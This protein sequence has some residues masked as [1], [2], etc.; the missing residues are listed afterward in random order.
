VSETKTPVAEAEDPYGWL[1]VLVI[2]ATAGILI[3][4]LVWPLILWGFV[5]GGAYSLAGMRPGYAGKLLYLLWTGI[6]VTVGSAIMAQGGDWGAALAAYARLQWELVLIGLSYFSSAT[7]APAGEI[8]WLHLTQ[9]PVIGCGIAFGPVLGILFGRGRYPEPEPS[10]GDA[11]RGSLPPE[12]EGTRKL[13]GREGNGGGI[14]RPVWLTGQSFAEMDEDTALELWG[15]WLRTGAVTGW[16]GVPKVGKSEAYTQLIAAMV[17]GM[18][19]FLGYPVTP[20]SV[21]IM[22]EETPSV[23]RDKA[24]TAAGWLSRRPY[25][26]PRLLKPLWRFYRARRLRVGMWW[27]RLLRRPVRDI[28]V[29]CGKALPGSKTVETLPYYV[30]IARRRAIA[31]GSRLIVF[32]SLNFWVREAITNDAAAKD[33]ARIFGELAAEGFAVLIV[34]HMNKKGQMAGPDSL[35]SQLDFRIDCLVPGDQDPRTTDLRQLLG[36][37]RFP[38]DYPPELRS[39]LYRLGEGGRLAAVIQKPTVLPA[40]DEEEDE[41]PVGDTGLPAIPGMPGGSEPVGS[42][43]I[44]WA[45]FQSAPYEWYT[46]D[47]I[48]SGVQAGGK[49]KASGRIKG[50]VTELVTEGKVERDKE[51]GVRGN[52]I[53]YRRAGAVMP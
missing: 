13:S 16:I 39:V 22:A 31:T 15:Y 19:G 9:L 28:H 20:T 45:W 52:P 2:G 8:L 50:Y 36:S 35:Y 32:D 37:G 4:W 17:L 51:K 18:A 26:G 23:Y 5:C 42:K 44:V 53:L 40:E 29:I 7:R 10:S 3:G 24:L 30:G 12:G 47:Q 1:A 11:S 21:V 25:H 46:A 34:H 38:R 43:G 49:L 48:V 33:A 41:S 6:S 27:L 14:V